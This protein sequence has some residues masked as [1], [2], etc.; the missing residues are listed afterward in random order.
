MKRFLTVLALIVV[1][2]GLLFSGF[3]ID[4]ASTYFG[5]RGEFA[6]QKVDDATNYETIQEVENTAR[7][8]ISSYEADK[9]T[10]MQY[11][12]SEDEEEQSWGEQAKMRAN[13]TASSYNNYIL[14]NSF[15]WEGNVPED[16]KTE[17]PLIQ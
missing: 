17:L 4:L 2:I 15:V 11:K 3:F 7:G 6:I 14:K 1:F 5:N 10:Y 16:I 8:M 12:E 13:R 9:N